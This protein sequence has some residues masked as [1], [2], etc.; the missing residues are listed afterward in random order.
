MKA[1][2]LKMEM[3]GEFRLALAEL[4]F[5][6]GII[7]FDAFG[8]S[9][10]LIQLIRG[11]LGKN[12]RLL[13]AENHEIIAVFYAINDKAGNEDAERF[14]KSIHELSKYDSFKYIIGISETLPSL[15]DLDRLFKQCTA[16]TRKKTEIGYGKAFYY[17]DFA[18]KRKKTID[19]NTDKIRSEI[20][21]IIGLV[22]DGVHPGKENRRIGFVYVEKNREA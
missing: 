1:N 15:T 16:I 6:D 12:V 3:S 17:S 4:K 10:E 7:G 13:Q 14:I 2:D 22:C 9:M 20:D 11:G 21:D 5:K 18:N 8:K 19:I